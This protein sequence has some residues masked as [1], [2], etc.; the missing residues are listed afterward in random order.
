MAEEVK[1]ALPRGRP[2]EFDV[3][4]ATAALERALWQRGFRGTSVEA[5]AE[6]AGL[7]LSSLYRTFGSKQGILDAALSR[8]EREMGVMLDEL[9]RGT[10]GLADIERFIARVGAV[11]DDPASPPGCFI[12]NTMVEVGDSMPEVQAS[13]SAYRS[14]IERAL[15]SALDRAV[16]AG[17]VATDSTADRAR[18]VQAALFGALAV[19]RSG[20]A[21]GARN[22]LRSITREL[23]RWREHRTGIGRRW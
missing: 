9:D 19:S 1:S 3:E 15:T 14:R 20:D 2:R 8:Y 12:V 7:S 4:T 18:L 13:A 6:D 22:A 16:S 23:G 21:E 10:D 5:L 17:E 11:L